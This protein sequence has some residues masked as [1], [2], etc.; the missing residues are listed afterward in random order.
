MINKS[1]FTNPGPDYGGVTLW[2][3]NDKLEKEEICRQ[4]DAICHAG[5]HAVITRT[6]NGLRTQYLSE[7]WM[8]D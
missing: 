3:L 4:L 8:A 6:F 1:A 2:M 5:I 7:E